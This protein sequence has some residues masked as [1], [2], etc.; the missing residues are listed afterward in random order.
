MP[1]P[2][3]DAGELDLDLSA[4]ISPAGGSAQVPASGDRE[5]GLEAGED[6]PGEA[7]VRH[8]TFG[9]QPQ[10]PVEPALAE[11]SGPVPAAS[12]ASVLDETAAYA[13]PPL[14]DVFSAFLAAEHGEPVPPSVSESM[15]R[16]LVMSDALIEQVSGRVLERLGD[17]AIQ[18]TVADVV[19]QVA[20][21][22]VRE[23]IDRL[24][25][26]LR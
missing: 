23:E 24:K 9:P 2:A 14:A 1:H 7:A 10:A 20:E 13:G 25:S 22:V 11:R 16:T 15:G 3:E 12:A 8:D 19:S 17:R 26:T 6:V 21:R 5:Q 18:E 4:W